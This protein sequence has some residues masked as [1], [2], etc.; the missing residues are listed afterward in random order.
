LRALRSDA[1]ILHPGPY[2]RGVEL[3][4]EVLADGRSRYVAQVGNGVFVRMAVLDFLV[5]GAKVVA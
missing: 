1:V 2:N 3:T 4:D 5:N